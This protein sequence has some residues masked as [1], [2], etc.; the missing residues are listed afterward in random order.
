MET[1]LPYCNHIRHTFPLKPSLVEWKLRDFL[2]AFGQAGRS[3]KPSLVEWKH[4]G[5]NGNMD[6]V[7]LP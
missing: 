1:A 7:E 3:L 2:I 4:K 5:R 6:P